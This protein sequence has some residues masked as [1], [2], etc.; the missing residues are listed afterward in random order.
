MSR[1]HALPVALCLSVLLAACGGG[2]GSSIGGTGTGGGTTPPPTP[3]DPC[4][5]ALLADTGD[6]AAIGSAAQGDRGPADKK[7]LID[8]DPRGRRVEAIALNRWAEE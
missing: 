6:V 7:T 2:G 4:A 3:T 1:I 8:G 5:T